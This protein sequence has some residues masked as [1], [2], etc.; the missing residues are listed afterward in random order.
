[1]C[2]PEWLSDGWFGPMY[3]RKHIGHM[4]SIHIGHIRAPV[5]PPPPVC[6][7][8]KGIHRE[9]RVGLKAEH[10]KNHRTR[11]FLSLFMLSGHSAALNQ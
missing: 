10:F 11:K 6:A 4:R 2:F 8:V 5:K 1:M 9:V 3:A 7:F